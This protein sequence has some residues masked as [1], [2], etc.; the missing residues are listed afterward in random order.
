MV[1]LL[2][3]L[4]VNPMSLTLTKA[5]PK[6]YLATKERKNTGAHYTPAE[7]ANFLAREIVGSFEN[8]ESSKKRKLKILDPAI[9]DGILLD[10]LRQELLKHQYVNIEVTGF[11]IDSHA[12]DVASQ[13]MKGAKLNHEDF[14]DHVLHNYLTPA[15]LFSS[16]TSN[17]LYDLVISNPPYIRTQVLGATE[18]RR[19][20]E[21]FGLSGRVDIYHAFL[22]TIA[23]VMASGGLV[24]LIVSNRF[25][26]TQGG[27]TARS[28]IKEEFD[29]LH[30]WDLGDT[31]MFEAAVLPALLLLRKKS[32]VGP[33]A[34]AKMTSIYSVN[35]DHIPV[36]NVTQDIFSALNQDGIIRAQNG[37]TYLIQTG[38]LNVGSNSWDTWRLSNKSTD[39]WL[40]KVSN[41]TH[42]LFSNL[43]KI[44]VGVKTTADKIFIRDDWDHFSDT[45]RPELIM[46][47]IT[48]HIADHYKAQKIRAGVLY[49]HEV[50]DGKKRAVNL[51]KYP[52]SLRYLENHRDLLEGRS[53]VSDAGRNWYEI[54][55]PQDPDEWKYPKIVFRDI[56]KKPYFWL[57]ESGAIVNGDCYWLSC[58]NVDKDLIYLSLAVANSKFITLFYDRKF[59]NKLYAERRR[60]ITQYVKDFPIPNPD[61]P[62]AREIISLVEKMMESSAP[63]DKELFEKI[64]TLVWHAFDLPV[65]KISW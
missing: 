47:L 23:S 29:V 6:G 5:Q 8:G 65:E 38:E 60:F 22:K 43:G 61:N 64:D 13:K 51:Q 52:K 2:V 21:N 17:A 9:G 37:Q 50:T 44:R 31:K 40:Q 19:L 26:T 36:E 24:G 55:V 54:W 57:D 16:S 11:D 28:I 46:P 53:Y 15:S 4:S 30:V 32:S 25:M 27:S 10:A 33:Q 14:L 3:S 49:T 12:L 63:L 42:C 7:M 62:H 18:S 34:A 45:E 39:N 41:G 35:S 56:S 20:S 1:K 58:K 59:N 48:H